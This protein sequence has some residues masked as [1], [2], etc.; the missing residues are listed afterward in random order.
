M[1]RK[2]PGVLASG[3]AGNDGTDIMLGAKLLGPSDGAKFRLT[4]PG[5]KSTDGIVASSWG[6]GW[7]VC[8]G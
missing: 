2:S 1:R 5:R 3:G 8:S 6:S 4:D 7:G